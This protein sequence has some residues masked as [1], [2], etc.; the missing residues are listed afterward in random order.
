MS[1]DDF[2]TAARIP[3]SW[4]DE[5][6]AVSSGFTAKR[7]ELHSARLDGRLRKRY[8]APFTA[9]NVPII[10]LDWLTSLVTAD[11]L[12]R[13][14]V[15]PTD[16]EMAFHFEAAKQADAESLEA[17]NAMTG[18]YDIPL[19]SDG[20]TGTGIAIGGPLSYSEQSPYVSGQI[21]RTIGVSEDDNG[22]G[23]SS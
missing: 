22:S 9:G 20:T 11:V 1:V 14:G 15:N 18:L 13:R 5:V 4:V 19:R 3:A 12:V 17:A 10:V 6:E 8:A 2:K 23:S 16:E 7:I 21:Q